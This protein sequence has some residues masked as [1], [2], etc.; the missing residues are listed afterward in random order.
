[1]NRLFI[2]VE[3]IADVLSA[4]YTVIR[5]YTDTAEDGDF[6]DLD[7]TVTLV[8]GQESYEY[9][10]SD[11]TSSTWYKT[12]YHGSGP[13]EGTKSSARK[14][15]TAAAY[16]T[17][18]E[19]RDQIQKAGK[20]SDV[21]IA[22][23]LDAV[24]DNIDRFC[25]RPDG[26]VAPTTA[27]ARLYAGDGS[28]VQWI[29]E[30]VEVTKV[31]VKDSASDTAY[32]TWTSDTWVAASGDPR[33]PNFNQKPYRFVMVTATGDYD[34][35]TDGVYTGL[36]GFRPDYENRRSVPTVRITA[37]WGYAETVPLS[38]KQ[39]TIIE[40]ARLYKRGQ[41]SFADAIANGNFGQLMFVKTLDPATQQFLINGRFVRPM[42]GRRY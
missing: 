15:E 36:Q 14:G 21:E 22:L 25:N 12:A 6:A 8:A 35:F 4:G 38:I 20:S 34:T 1:M 26:F 3:S 5:V 10:D 2:T 29:D 19:V 18:T 24:S 27:T 31:E 28:T 42:V 16:A 11:G 39:A 30:C 32:V 13:G 17:V 40:V 33:R 37:R 23:L 9:I 41:S 7:G